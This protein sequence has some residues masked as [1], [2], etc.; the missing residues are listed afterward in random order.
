MCLSAPF[1]A[2]FRHAT[3]DVGLFVDVKRLRT[4]LHKT[5][6]TQS[7]VNAKI[8]RDEMSGYVGM[9]TT[10]KAIRESCL[11]IAAQVCHLADSFALL[12]A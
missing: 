10:R 6:T 8:N 7:S 3:C 4:S 11:Y 12:L 2:C 5:P 1:S 9:K